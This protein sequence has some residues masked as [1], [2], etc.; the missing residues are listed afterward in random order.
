MGL[1]LTLPK[2]VSASVFGSS[3]WI[4][5]SAKV[6]AALWLFLGDCFNSFTH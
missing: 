6:K 5:A 1:V 4:T 3:P 2:E